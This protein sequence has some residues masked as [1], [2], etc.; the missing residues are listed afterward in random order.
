M[1]IVLLKERKKKAKKT[2][3]REN[4]EEKENQIKE[5]PLCSRNKSLKAWNLHGQ[6]LQGNSLQ[7]TDE[8]VDRREI[9]DVNIEVEV[10]TE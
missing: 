4:R 9:D 8:P 2:R 6:S 3:K 5:S 1:I 10:S 7:G